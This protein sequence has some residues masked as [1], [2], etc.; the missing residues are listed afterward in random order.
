MSGT[1]SNGA[2]SRG[3]PR[4]APGLVCPSYR[5]HDRAPASGREG[6]RS[7]GVKA[8]PGYAELPGRGHERWWTLLAGGPRRAAVF[9]EAAGPDTLL[10]GDPWTINAFVE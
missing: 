10:H 1:R 6:L 2:A 7:H 8:S 3:G 5:S 9:G 4:R